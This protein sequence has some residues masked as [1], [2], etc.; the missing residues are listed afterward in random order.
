MFGIRT[1]FHHDTMTNSTE[2]LD[3]KAIRIAPNEL[4][5]DD[6]KMYKEIYN[7]TATYTKQPDFY[8]GFGTP[9]SVF[10]EHDLNLHKQR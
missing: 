8:A 6:V 1:V 7:Q 2:R 4:H 9:H 3:S 10:A 5:I